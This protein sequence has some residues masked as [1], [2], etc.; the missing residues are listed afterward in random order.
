[1]T[2]QKIVLSINHPLDPAVA[3]AVYRYALA[4]I[5]VVLAAGCLLALGAKGALWGLLVAACC[6]TVYRFKL[7]GLPSKVFMQT[8]WRVVF[9]MVLCGC[10]YGAAAMGW[11]ES[12]TAY[13]AW[14]LVQMP[15]AMLDVYCVMNGRNVIGLY[16]EVHAL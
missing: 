1:M 6:L 4:S 7:H 5:H 9:S 12:T 3:P 15:L 10:A 8:L 16:P 13:T 11:V 2:M 14:L